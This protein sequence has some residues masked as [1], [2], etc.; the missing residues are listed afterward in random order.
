MKG[1]VEVVR[2][3]GI[4]CDFCEVKLTPLRYYKPETVRQETEV[5]RKAAEDGKSF[6]AVLHLCGAVECQREDVG[7]RTA[8]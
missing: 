3:C 8:F 7:L 5:N 1:V 6:L 2:G 4:G